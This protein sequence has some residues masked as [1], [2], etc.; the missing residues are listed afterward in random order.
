MKTVKPLVR[1][2]LRRAWLLVLLQPC[3]CN[4]PVASDAAGSFA[5]GTI[6]SATLA[7]IVNA[8]DPLSRRIGAYYAQQRHIPEKN[9][10][11]VSFAAGRPGMTRGEFD[12]VM[13]TVNARVPPSVQA[14]ALAWTEPYR[15]DCMSITTAFAAGYDEAF[16]AKGCK[17]TRPSPYFNTDSRHPHEDF[18][19]RPAMLLAG[20]GFDDVKALIDRGVAADGTRPPGTGYLVSTNDTARNVRSRFYPGILLMQSDRFRLKLIHSNTVRYRTDIMFYFTGLARV[21]G[22]DTN[23]FLPGAIAD[24]LTSSGGRLIDSRQMSSLRW[25]EAGATGSY[26]TVVEP[27]AFTQKFPRPDIVINRY[28]NGET[29]MEAY[30]KSVA[31]PGQGVFIGEPLAA[32]FREMNTPLH[33][34]EPDLPGANTRD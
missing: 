9:L 18:G 5:G 3:A 16:C 10:I 29:L 21:A 23:R 22:I 34:G 13:A 17:A 4:A 11:H 8:A 28:L 6:E 19:W 27:C 32:P 31:W 12:Q 33:R 14:Y 20:T 2:L 7:V 25:L 1:E 26:G 30:W 24:H 15:V